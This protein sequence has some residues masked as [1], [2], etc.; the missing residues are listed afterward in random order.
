MIRVTIER[1]SESVSVEC[2]D[3]MLIGALVEQGALQGAKV[4]NTLI[5]GRVATENTALTDGDTVVQ[6]PKSGDQG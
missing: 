1:G 5:N 4:V 3:G 2:E 6:T